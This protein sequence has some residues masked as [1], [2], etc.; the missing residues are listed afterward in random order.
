MTDGLSAYRALQLL[1]DKSL[2]GAQPLPARLDANPQ[3]SGVGFSLLGFHF[4]TPM[5]NLSEILTVPGFTQLPGV[6][7]WVRGLA[8]VR[9][10]LL[11]VFDMATYFGGRLSGAKKWQRL[12]VI[13]REGIYAGLWVARM[14]GMQYFPMDARNALPPKV[15]PDVL[16]PFIDGYFDYEG[17]IWTVFQPLKLLE[18]KQFLEVAAS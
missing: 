2:Q 1:A 13:D 17:R 4:V 14:F 12:L 8:N 10:R 16:A 7:S 15:L 6:K 5:S 3:W 11:P 9:G 18:D